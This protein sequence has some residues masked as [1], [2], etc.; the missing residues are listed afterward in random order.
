MRFRFTLRDTEHDTVSS[1]PFDATLD[2][3]PDVLAIFPLPNAVLLPHQTLQLNIFEPRY[4]AMVEDALAAGRHIGMIQPRPTA[5]VGDPVPVYP[6]GCAG[7]ITSFQET[8]DGRFL[9]VLTGVCRYRV[10]EELA[11]ERGYRRIRPDFQSFRS[12]LEDA[13]AARVDLRSLEDSLK[14]YLEM[15]GL[16]LNAQLLRKL[17]GA[18]LVDFLTVNLPLEVEDK[19]ALLES[20]SS[21]DRARLLRSALEI[22]V[23]SS[24]A[25]DQRLH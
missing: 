21:V 17:P 8:D 1:N 7:R 24:G 13:S 6:V 25:P 2:D 4:V 11:L 19:Q 3:L 12:D 20:S 10:L 9:I 22:A 15:N 14:S 5:V 18:Q 16:K 23:K